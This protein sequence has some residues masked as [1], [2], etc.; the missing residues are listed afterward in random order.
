MFKI[1]SDE[2]I[3]ASHEGDTCRDCGRHIAQAQME[4]DARDLLEKA[5]V[6]REYAGSLA[7]WK[8]SITMSNEGFE[9][10]KR[11][12]VYFTEEEF[13]TLKKLTQLAD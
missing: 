4:A 12:C 11:I 10:L 6:S 3:I 2:K 13:E 5:V 7:W 9:A 1:L 8:L